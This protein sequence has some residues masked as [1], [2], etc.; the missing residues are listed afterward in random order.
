MRQSPTITESPA[1]QRSGMRFGRMLTLAGVVAALGVLGAT[2]GCMVNGY[3]RGPRYAPAESY[4]NNGAGGVRFGAASAEVG[5]FRCST[6]DRVVPDYDWFLDGRGFFKVCRSD[7][8]PRQIVFL[9]DTQESRICIFPALELGAD[10]VQ[11]F[12]REGGTGLQHTCVDRRK[13]PE[14]GRY[15][16]AAEF[17][18]NIAFNA[19]FIAEY[20]SASRLQMC[21]GGDP[22]AIEGPNY[23]FCPGVTDNESYHSYGRVD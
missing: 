23:Y 16:F 18:P 15:Y 7:S 9:G 12:P 3:A 22:A 6:D 14:T 10:N 8:E 4:P 20:S 13:D 5:D 17:D 1:G 11:V 21:L 2:T 19:V